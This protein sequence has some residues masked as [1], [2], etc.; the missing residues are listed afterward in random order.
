MLSDNRLKKLAENLVSYSCELKKGEKVWIDAVGIDSVFPSLL[1]KEIYR[2]GGMPFVV[3]HDNR[4]KREILSCASDEMLEFMAKRDAEFMSNM[5]AYIGIRGGQNSF[6]LSDIPSDRFSA[7][8]KIYSHRVHHNIRVAKTKWVVLRYPTE[9]MSQLASMSTEAFEDFYFDVCNLDYAKMD[10][11]MTPLIELMDK[12]DKVRILAKDTD[13]S[14]SI[15]G[16]KAIKCSGKRNIPDG[17]VFTAP[18]KNS[19][20]GKILYNVPSIQNGFK[21]ESVYLEFKDGK[22]VDVKA[23]DTK[24]ANAIFDTDEG[25]RHVGEFALGLNPYI[26][27][28]I[29]DILFD[30]KISGSIHFTP[31][32]CYDEA[33]N[34]NNSA[35]HWDLVQ[36]HTPD[37][38]G[39]EIWFDDV[40]VR[41][42]GRFVLPALEGLNPENLK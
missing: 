22:I 23:N 25:A 1:V 31:G 30:E 35:V 9:G 12:T 29:G 34:N 42:D 28:A 26:T 33:S 4:I 36:K 8:S 18:V 32:S 7:Y 24:R 3:V 37:V 19:V 5:D 16:I 40:L 27:N 17:E 15:A 39:G 2:A 20:N 14:F 6:E 11:A 13:L 38:G 10:R 41:K 21:F